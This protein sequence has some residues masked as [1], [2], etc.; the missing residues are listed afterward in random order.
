MKEQEMR[1][2]VKKA[3]I[4]NS[5]ARWLLYEVKNMYRMYEKLGIDPSD[6][7]IPLPNGRGHCMADT[8][9]NLVAVFQDITGLRSLDDET[10]YSFYEV[11]DTL[12]HLVTDIDP[13][14]GERNWTIEFR[15][16]YSGEVFDRF[17]VR[18]A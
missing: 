9:E 1:E 8:L 17:T 10:D 6:V 11:I 7:E 2:L 13:E 14:N 5:S 16:D 4:E 18:E 3:L 12:V 15:N